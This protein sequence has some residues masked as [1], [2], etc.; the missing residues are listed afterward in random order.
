MISVIITSYKEPK[1]I[2]KAIKSIADRT[3][4]GLP[5]DFE[6]IQVSPD[7]E[8]LDAGKQQADKF[9]LGNRFIQIVDPSQGK[10]TALN[11]AFKKARGEIL[12]LTDGDVYFGENAIAEILRPFKIENVG[13]V[14]GRPIASNNRKTLMGYFGHFFAD[15]AHAKRS[16]VFKE[17]ENSIHIGKKEFFGM[18]GYIMAIRK[19]P[20]LTVPKDMLVDDTY[21]TFV[22]Y[23][24]GYRL[25]YAPKA[26]AYVKYVDNL[27]DYIKQRRRTL[28]GHQKLGALIEEAGIDSQRSLSDELRYA[29][30]PI[31]HA[32]N[33]RELV[34][35]TLLYPLRVVIWLSVLQDKLFGKR[36]F[37]KTWTRAESSK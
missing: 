21:I 34:Y 18:S 6:L 15:V 27:G 1:T 5:E 35:A 7:K 10:P 23:Q 26:N 28:V 19:Q 29:L 24:A 12:V 30:F 31:R 20:E 33:I 13:G 36:D 2:A 22:T 16:D 8:T 9:K 14:S 11:L 32:R 17:Y 3:Y 4:S 37:K 25:A